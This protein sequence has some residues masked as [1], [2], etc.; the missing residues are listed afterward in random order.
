MEAT[1][2]RYDAILDQALSALERAHEGNNERKR[3][4]EQRDRL[5]SRTLDTLQ[6]L[7]EEE[8]AADTPRQ[9]VW[10]RLFR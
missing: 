9:G 8:A 4:I 1:L 6:D 2:A 10:A 7:V 5:L 3:E